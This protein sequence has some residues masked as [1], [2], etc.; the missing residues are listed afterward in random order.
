MINA[1]HLTASRSDRGVL[2]DSAVAGS[3]DRARQL[4]NGCECRVR[5]DHWK[6]MSAE[7]RA[8]FPL[9]QL[10]QMQA[11]AARPQVCLLGCTSQ[12]GAERRR[13]SAV[14]SVLEVSLG[15]A[16]YCWNCSHLFAAES[17]C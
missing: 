13:N 8:V 11:K 15:L 12:H 4:A 14:W 1:F 10:Q 6:G 16:I 5:P 17:F 9:W 3:A 2:A 7:Q